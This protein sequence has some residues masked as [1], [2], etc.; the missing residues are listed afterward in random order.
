MV[1]AD[2]AQSA[3][4]DLQ[5]SGDAKQRIERAASIKGETVSA[6]ILAS[7]QEQADKTIDRHD[8]MVLAR[9]DATRF[10]HALDK[11]SPLN[12]RLQAALDEHERR[13]I[14]R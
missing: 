5:L 14:S 12:D 10:F 7:A 2:T 11:P 9:D 8:S 6:F 4:I 1:T 13:V 3:R